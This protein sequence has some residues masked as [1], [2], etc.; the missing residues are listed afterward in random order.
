MN[1][2]LINFSKFMPHG[3]VSIDSNAAKKYFLSEV[4]PYVCMASLQRLIRANTTNNPQ[5]VRLEMMRMFVES[6]LMKPSKTD[7]NSL[8]SFFSES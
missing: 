5:L 6:E 1:S 3:Q 8:K 2:N 4:L 7:E